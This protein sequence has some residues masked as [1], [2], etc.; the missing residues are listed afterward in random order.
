MANIISAWVKPG[1]RVEGVFWGRRGTNRPAPQYTK[2]LAVLWLPAIRWV[3][4]S[5]V[6][7]AQEHA[8]AH[9]VTYTRL[10]RVG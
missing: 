2:L 8:L 7:L 4:A 3:P 5:L 10:F 6:A 9:S 1:G